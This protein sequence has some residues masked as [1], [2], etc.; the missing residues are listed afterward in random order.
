M[1][2]DSIY[3]ISFWASSAQNKVNFNILSDD[4]VLK[5]ITDDEGIGDGV[6]KQFTVDTSSL[7]GEHVFKLVNNEKVQLRI[8]DFTVNVIVNPGFENGKDGW[9]SDFT[10]ASVA[11]HSGSQ[12]LQATK[13]NK[14]ISQTLNFDSIYSISFWAS[15]AQNK[16]NFNILSDDVVLK[17]ITDDEGIGDGVWKQFTVDTSSLT[18][19]HVFKLVNNEKVQ[20]RIDDFTVNTNEPTD[21]ETSPVN[22]TISVAYLNTGFVVI[23][24]KDENDKV[25]PN[26]NI[27]YRVDNNEIIN[28]STDINGQIIFSAL[29]GNFSVSVNFT[30]NENYSSSNNIV[31]FSNI[32][33]IINPFINS[34]FE[35]GKL[36]T[37]ADVYGWNVTGGAAH[38]GKRPDGQISIFNGTRAL[39]LSGNYYGFWVSQYLNFDYIDKVTFKYYALDASLNWFNYNLTTLIGGNIIENVPTADESCWQEVT[40]DTHDI[41]GINLFELSTGGQFTP[42]RLYLDD[43]AVVYNNE[44]VS[45]FTYNA[46]VDGENVTVNFINTAIGSIN[47]ILW[48]F[49]DNTTSNLINPTHIFKPG[50]HNVSLTVYNGENF[51]NQTYTL[52]LNFPTIDGKMYDGIQDAINNATDSATIEIPNDLTEDLTIDKNLTLNFNGNKLDG[53]INVNNGA[54]V[55]V[56][57]I[58]GAN[59]FSTDDS[60]KLTITESNIADTNITLNTG[61][62][63]LDGNDFTGSYITVV[64]ANAVIANNNIANGGIKVNGGKSKIN[65]N[66]LSGNDVAITQT[67]GETNITSNIITDNNIGVNVT[68]GTSNI[69][70]NVIYNNNNVALAYVGTVDASNNW[71]GVLQATFSTT[72]PDGYVD[73]YAPNAE[74][75]VWLVLTLNSKE[76]QFY[77]T[78]NHTIIANLTTNSNGD[79]TSSLG[80][81]PKF[82]L[83]VSTELG[84]ASD[85][86]VEDS[87]GE[88]T[89][90]TGKLPSDEVS[91]TIRGEEY[92]LDNVAIVAK[93]INTNLT[94]E[95]VENGVVIVTLKDVDGNLISDANVTYTVNTGDQITDKTVDGKITIPGLKGTV[96]V[97]ADY[98]GIS[99]YPY[100][101][102]TT[103]SEN[104]HFVYD[105]NI[106]ITIPESAKTNETTSITIQLPTDAQGTVNIFVDTKKINTTQVTG[107]TIIPLNDVGIGEHV[108]E[109]TYDNDDI[110]Y[111]ANK[112]QVLI[113]SKGTPTITATGCAVGEN[114]TAIVEVNIDG[115]TGIVL[116]EVGGNKYFAE[117][118]KANAIVNVVG[119]K[120]GNYTANIKYIGDEKFT[121]TTTTAEI[122]VSEVEDKSITELKEELAEAKENATQL[123]NNL[124]D[125]NKKIENLTTQ[126]NETQSNATKLAEDLDAANAK[127]DNLTT[128]LNKTQANATQLFNN[129][130]EANAKVENLTTQLNET[131]SNATKLAEDL[132]DANQKAEN[133]TIQLGDAQ[134][135]IHTLSAD[136]ISTT[137]AAN[138][139]N[140]KALTNGNIQVTL[141]ANGTALANKTVNVI[142]NGV[143]YNGTTGEDGVAKIAVKFASAGTY[144]ATVTFAGDDTYKSS[145]GTSKVVVSKKA[146]K[147]T[148][149]KKSFK[150]KVKTKKVKITLKSGSTALKSKKITLKV[151]GKTYTAKTNSKGVAT[152]KVTKLTKKGT[153]T[154]TVKFAGDKAYKAITKKGKITIK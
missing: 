17:T 118:E 16:V 27:T 80:V 100:Y 57:N 125:A 67:E 122:K 120:P 11:A 14:Y 49:D 51:V 130:T 63:T 152:I 138:N 131:Q 35:Q 58:A 111:P 141:K 66:V 140:I 154:Y 29:T 32:N 60:S 31:N 40:I 128:Q 78:Q 90:T 3:S 77:T 87:I 50:N 81:L 135:Q 88:F 106:N 124:T 24:L 144:Y 83:P 15:S 34:D 104:F 9:D 95:S 91:F 62:I 54:K 97:V 103:A 139:L 142:I 39:L 109:V 148:A 121:Q 93:I 129:L 123:F 117:L 28:E 37:Y 98:A 52:S 56:N 115:A 132:E 25:I 1:N 145:I 119:L 6:W 86:N 69:N 134:K 149:P 101:N 136:L 102:S 96:T 44:I 38:G 146:T 59:S 7:T 147:I 105:G 20:L 19:E 5:T 21:E 114:E 116:V 46:N 2:F 92:T 73:V 41:Q 75:P 70:F 82:T 36:D 107:T 48:S 33:F 126:L 18:G 151:N 47:K 89:L 79:D 12:G 84:E 4:V 133:L 143:V 43:F 137:V 26:V 68:N 13:A 45:D 30:G 42:L 94:I 150:A 127:V 76:T 153:F 53:N 113:V 85:V 112:T 74:Q 99:E 108:V 72:V 110:Y 71:F 55:T 8:D 23:S 22:T 61:N 64:N 10:V 65:N